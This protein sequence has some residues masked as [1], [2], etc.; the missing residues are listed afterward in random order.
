MDAVDTVPAATITVLTRNPSLVIGLTFVGRDWE[1]TA[2]EDLDGWPD[3]DV[4]VVDVGSTTEGVARLRQLE[5]GPKQPATALIIGDEDVP[6]SESEHLLLR[7][8]TVDELTGHIDVLLGGDVAAEDRPPAE[9]SAAASHSTERVV[10]HASVVD[11]KE[12]NR[13]G[14]RTSLRGWVDR[15]GSR[16]TGR[17]A[18]TDAAVWTADEPMDPHTT[19]G[20]EP[21]AHAADVAPSDGDVDLV[22]DLLT[23]DEADEG[24]GTGQASGSQS[25]RPAGPSTHEPL[26]R[27]DTA[28]TGPAPTSGS[29]TARDPLT[30][31]GAVQR[32]AS[33]FT[34]RD[35]EA[36]TPEA[37]MRRRLAGVIT[38]GSELESLVHELPLLRSLKGVASLVVEE[39]QEVLEADTAAYITRRDDGYYILASIGLSNVERRLV[40]PLDQP[41]LA[42]VDATGG[43]LLIDPIDAA[44]AAV[45]GIGGAHT[46]SFMA[47]SIAAGSGR[48]GLLVAGRDRPLTEQDLDRLVALAREAAPGIAVAQLLRRLGALVIDRRDEQQRAQP[49][50]SGDLGVRLSVDH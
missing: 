27:R 48:F 38:A 23:E 40:A 47:A 22:I 44:H 12:G 5:D 4:V 11:A 19:P 39:V 41:M 2:V 18:G 24:P 35:R 6:T 36:H 49:V 33:R 32:S 28:A 20:E 3:S 10:D 30:R 21:D 16:R 50:S 17:P 1:V 7:P 13:P 25:D 34:A 29:S 46:E 37:E 42:E 26:T 9:A 14:P 8:F 15:L 31:S 43:G 45:S